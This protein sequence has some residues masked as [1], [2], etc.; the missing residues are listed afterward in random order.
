MATDTTTRVSRAGEKLIIE[1]TQYSHELVAFMRSLPHARWHATKK[2]WE[3]AAT[4]LACH[5]IEGSGYFADGDLDDAVRLR[6]S[7]WDDVLD[8]PPPVV[9]YEFETLP[10][11]HQRD[12]FHFCWNKYAAMLPIKMGGGKTK[13]AIDI[14]RNRGAKR[15]LIVCPK[16]VIGVWPYQFQLHAPGLYTVRTLESGTSAVKAQKLADAV[17]IVGE[18]DM[19]L[20]VVVNYESVWRGELGA[21]VRGIRWNAVVCDESQ[22]I[23]A[24]NS[25]QSKFMAHLATSSDFRLCLSGTPMRNSPLDLYGQY[26]FLEPAIFGTS[27][28][29]FRSRYAVTNPTIPQ[30]VLQLINQGELREKYRQIAFECDPDLSL[31]PESHVDVP[32]QL[33]GKS[34][35]VYDD[36]SKDFYSYLDSG[37]AVVAANVLV[38]ITRLQ[39]ITSG[40]VVDE[41]DAEQA[42]H[43]A[44]RDALAE[45]LDEMPPDE[46]CVVFARFRHD[47]SSVHEAAKLAGRASWELSGRRNNLADWQQNDVL[48]VQI[49]A[50]A[51]GIDLTA[52][53]FA[54]FYS[55]THSLADYAQACARLVRP[56]QTR[57][58]TFYHLNCTDTIDRTIRTAYA[59]K[60]EIIDYVMKGESDE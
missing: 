24:A 44:K 32:L 17:R 57:P 30:Q 54:V 33:D 58:V 15:V 42:L 46:P 12:A 6:A 52:A 35:K 43:T 34:R 3:C 59:K 40:Y 55:Y 16:A 28:S 38:R 11:Q 37:E 22:K 29:R 39:Q 51:T 50:G 19:A 56:G 36:L 18:R 5:R 60:Q 9:G 47:L 27:Y 49:Q 23:A 21:A 1:G 48:A 2:R 14:V 45:L 13:L 20:A 10:W 31:P 25:R 8:D 26:R 4:P 53:R 7:F 41:Q